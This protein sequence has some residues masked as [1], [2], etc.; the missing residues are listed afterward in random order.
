MV[1]QRSTLTDSTFP[2][3]TLFLSRMGGCLAGR[4]HAVNAA[5]ELAHDLR[6]LGI[7]EVQVVGDREWAGADGGEV[8]PALGHR[9]GAAALRIG[10]AVARR[11]IAGHR[12]AA[13][14]ADRKS[15]V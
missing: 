1:P 8:A 14:G 9:L 4:L 12:E 7:A 3:T 10:L 5:D 11:A 15:V 6:A 2:Y 13:V